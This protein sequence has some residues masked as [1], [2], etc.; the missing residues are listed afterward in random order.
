MEDIDELILE[1]D[2]IQ[3]SGIIHITQIDK[4]YVVGVTRGR[5][6]YKENRAKGSLRLAVWDE[7]DA[8]RDVADRIEHALSSD[9]FAEEKIDILRGRVEKTID[10]CVQIGYQNIGLRFIALLGQGKLASKRVSQEKLDEKVKDY[11]LKTVRGYAVRSI[12]SG[13]E[14][15]DETKV[16]KNRVIEKIILPAQQGKFGKSASKIPL[17]EFVENFNKTSIP[18]R[19]LNKKENKSVRIFPL[20]QIS[21]NDL[22]KVKPKEKKER[23]MA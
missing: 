6:E 10:R 13:R 17:K 1:L 16:Y 12:V 20:D 21:S 2:N 5:R 4:S 14:F 22:K 7:K 15:T 18:V 11:L 3:R 19:N 9:D 23:E 8:L